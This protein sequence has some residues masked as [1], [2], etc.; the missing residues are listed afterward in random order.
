LATDL[1]VVLPMVCARISFGAP[2][3]GPVSTVLGAI[4]SPVLCAW[5]IDYLEKGTAGPCTV[6]T[7]DFTLT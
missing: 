5:H 1:P 2:K 6:N 4:Y 7:Q 3:I